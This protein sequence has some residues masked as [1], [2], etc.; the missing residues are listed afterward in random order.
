MK[1]LNPITEFQGEYCWLSN[2]YPCTVEMDFAYYPS[3]EHAYQ[4]AKTILPNIRMV[5]QNPTLPA[6]DAKKIGSGLKLPA[7]WEE[8]KIRVMTQL[9]SQKFLFNPELGAKLVATRG[10]DI[11][12][13]NY[14]GDT[15]W[16]VCR[17]KGQNHLGEIIMEIRD[18]LLE[19]WDKVYSG[20]I[21]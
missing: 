17:G 1:T 7:M 11:I 2:F 16:G 12:E 3:V 4:A 8:T 10:R 20:D 19:Q 18:V 14:W 15:F 6:G 5:L 21:L 9:V 13:G